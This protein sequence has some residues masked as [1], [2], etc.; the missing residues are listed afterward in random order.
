ME[1]RPLVGNFGA[2]S[3]HKARSPLDNSVGV[4]CDRLFLL[5]CVAYPL[6]FP[7]VPQV[8]SAAALGAG[9]FA[10]IIGGLPRVQVLLCTLSHPPPCTPA[11]TLV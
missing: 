9:F 1:R 5:L 10:H 7:F 11:L 8:A 6:A 2:E 4:W 3:I